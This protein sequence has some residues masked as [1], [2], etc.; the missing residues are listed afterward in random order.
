MV[1]RHLEGTEGTTHL[2][3]DFVIHNRFWSAQY[4]RDTPDIGEIQG[5]VLSQL[6]ERQIGRIEAMMASREFPRQISMSIQLN[7]SR[8]IQVD[9]QCVDICRLD[10]R[11]LLCRFEGEL[12]N[13]RREWETVAA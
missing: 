11:T 6:D 7:G 4:Y 13:A 5:Y 3:E 12:R 1:E 10:H 2:C 9:V 8:P